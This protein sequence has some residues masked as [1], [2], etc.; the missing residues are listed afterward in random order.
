MVDGVVIAGEA[1]TVILRPWIGLEL[2]ARSAR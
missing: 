2:A 1:A